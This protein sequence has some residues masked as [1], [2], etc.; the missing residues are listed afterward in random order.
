MDGIE[1]GLRCNGRGPGCL[2][3]DQVPEVLEGPGVLVMDV[4]EGGE[5]LFRGQVVKQVGGFQQLVLR[6]PAVQVL[7]NEECH[8]S[9]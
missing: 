1:I 3:A 5:S 8:G 7:V 6:H 4:Q 2:G 9:P